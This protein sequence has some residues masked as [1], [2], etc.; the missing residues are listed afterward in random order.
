MFRSKIYLTS[1]VYVILVVAVVPP[2]MPSFTKR[3][4]AE[5]RDEEHLCS[6]ERLLVFKTTVFLKPYSS[7]FHVKKRL[8]GDHLAF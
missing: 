5:L 7:N 3:S 2:S 4:L 6:N 1:S 8:T